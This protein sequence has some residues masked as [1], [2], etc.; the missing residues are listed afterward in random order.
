MRYIIPIIVMLLAISCQ[1]PQCLSEKDI[2]VVKKEVAQLR[3]WLNT[4]DE[5]AIM[6]KV[7]SEIRNTYT[8]A[9]ILDI[10]KEAFK[11]TEVDY[12]YNKDEQQCGSINVS[13]NSFEIIAIDEGFHRA[14]HTIMITFSFKDEQI[15]ITNFGFAG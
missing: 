8:D 12:D 1:Q 9:R 7:S 2:V 5:V 11:V 6:K 13:F 14:E 10:L 4:N 15:L 3:Q